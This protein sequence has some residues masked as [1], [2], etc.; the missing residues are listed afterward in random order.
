M[1]AL[2][3]ED[4][5]NILIQK[6]KLERDKRVCDRIKAILL[7]DEGW[8]LIQIARVLLIT[9]D[10][11]RQHIKEFKS[12][13]KLKPKNGGSTELLSE[14]QAIA[15]EKHLEMHT[16]MFT[17][18][19]VQYIKA[20][21]DVSYSVPGMHKWLFRHGFSY[22]KPTVIP[23]KAN[24]SAQQEWIKKYEDFKQRLPE[25][26]TICFMDGVH[27][28]HNS[29]AHYG[30]IKRG[31]RKN[32][33][34]NSGRQRLNISGAI[35]LINSKFIFRKD[36][37]LN[38]LSTVEFLKQVENA[39][40]SLEKVHVFCDNAGYYKGDVVKEFLK[41]SKVEL[42]FLPPYSP[43][44]NPIER[45]WKFLK[46]RVIY[47]TYYEDFGVLNKPLRGFLLP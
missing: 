21:F 10:T 30:W 26:E 17:K 33:P 7:Y 29:Q 12:Q 11:V 23:G 16:Y 20:V 15:L 22:K 43:N 38:A 46:D 18:D 3:T 6:H 24:F 37:R 14:R 45:V 39:Y 42:H 41:K 9:D 31:V 5:R 25:N 27:P 1:R 2:L 19:I 28:T 40:P 32:L 4:E 47:N 44:L 34:T 8:T 36:E 13:R 35:D